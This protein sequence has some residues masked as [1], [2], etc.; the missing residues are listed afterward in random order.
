MYKTKITELH[1]NQ[2]RWIEN[3]DLSINTSF[4]SLSLTVYSNHFNENKL[5]R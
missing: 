1:K 2:E 5:G 4:E 3:E